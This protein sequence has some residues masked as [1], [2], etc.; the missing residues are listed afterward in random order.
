MTQAAVMVAVR[1]FGLALPGPTPG[2]VRGREHDHREGREQRRRADGLARDGAGG[3]AGDRRD[4]ER[5]GVAPADAP[6]ACVAE[7]SRDRAGGDD[8][9]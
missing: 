9:Q 7:A 3:D 8:D 5:A 6:G 1:R 4:C 2:G